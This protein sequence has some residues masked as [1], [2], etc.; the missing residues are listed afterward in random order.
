LGTIKGDA[1][2][3]VD[4]PD[5][6]EEDVEEGEFDDDVDWGDDVV[7]PPVTVPAFVQETDEGTV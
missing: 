6:G 1:A 5:A 4:V 7:D 3:F 2:P